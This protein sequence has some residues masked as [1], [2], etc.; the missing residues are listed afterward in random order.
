MYVERFCESL[1][2]AALTQPSG[3][4]EY[5]RS[6]V[7]KG[8][9]MSKKHFSGRNKEGKLRCPV[10]HKF[11]AYIPNGVTFGPEMELALSQPG[12]LTQCEHCSAMLEF[13][14]GDPTS[15]T[16]RRARPE[17]IDRFNRL[18]QEERKSS[19]PELLDY[20]RKYGQ[21]PPGSATGYRFRNTHCRNTRRLSS[22]KDGIFGKPS[23]P[24]SPSRESV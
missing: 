2:A 9:P 13:S 10:C 21:M 15:P 22:N 1:F 5:S 6:N 3:C 20:V 17:R 16:V 7:M 4:Q 19:I 12:G 14:G 23:A 8:I 24:L 18:A 11:M